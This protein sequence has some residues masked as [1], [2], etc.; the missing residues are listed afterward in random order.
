MVDC[1]VHVDVMLA[2]SAYLARELFTDSA[3]IF[4]LVHVPTS[5]FFALNAIDAN[6]PRLWSC[7]SPTRVF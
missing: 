4:V 1:F 3:Y 5:S 6:A 2:H 7:H